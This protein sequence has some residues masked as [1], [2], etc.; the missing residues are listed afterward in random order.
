M[1]NQF[2]LLQF[3]YKND[4][5]L[6]KVY[7]PATIIIKKSPPKTTTVYD[8]YWRFA[9]ERQDVFFNKLQQKS[10]P[11]S[12]DSIL[13]NHKFTNAYRASD[14]VSQYLINSVIYKGSQ[15][16]KELFFRIILFKT[17][18]K[19]STW[20][21]LQNEI[22]P[23][24]L[25]NYNFE[26][27]DT[28]LKKEMAEGR[29]IYSAAYIMTS[30]RSSFGY[31]KKHQ[32]HLKLIEKMIQENVPN[33]IKDLTSME[34]L[35]KLLLS[36]PTIGEFLAFQ[37]TIDIN[38]STLTNFSEMDFVV[39]GPGAIDGISKC[40][41]NLNDWSY[42]DIIKY[43]TEK[44]YIEF[45]RLN[46]SFNDLWGRPLQLIDCQNL[47]CEVSKYARVAHPE[48]SGISGR[49]RIK[50]KYRPLINEIHYY[51]P[52]KWGINDKINA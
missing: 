25:S 41:S 38:Y 6:N 24:T 49:T 28:V 39:A 46:L 43:V 52:P 8:T 44:Q 30:G 42:S 13:L 21:L 47:F 11:W 10:M 33:R 48:F 22:G 5:I 40:F 51:Y 16:P 12:T 18:N 15:D 31:S 3:E 26:I 17:F 29:P 36:Y 27:Y 35:Y 45:D 50:Q 1:P 14:R 9:K 34:N 4:N 37:Y 2:K 32:N 7:F 20:E 23:I 19:I